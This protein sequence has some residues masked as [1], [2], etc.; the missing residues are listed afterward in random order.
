M[1]SQNRRRINEPPLELNKAFMKDLIGGLP[2]PK[3]ALLRG[4]LIKTDD[5]QGFFRRVY[6]LGND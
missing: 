2:E 3:P 1:N 6:P 5:G 4:N